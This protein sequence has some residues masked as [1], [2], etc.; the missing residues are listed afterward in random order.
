MKMP[1]KYFSHAPIYSMSG[2]QEDREHKIKN[3]KN[4]LK[5]SKVFRKATDIHNK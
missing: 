1:L 5:S 3:A 2:G 4:F